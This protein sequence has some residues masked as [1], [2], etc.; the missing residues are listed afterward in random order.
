[1]NIVPQTPQKRC[2]RGDNCVHPMG[3]IQPATAEHFHRSKKCKDGLFTQCKACVLAHK[4]E[5]YLEH[6]AEKLAYNHRYYQLNRESLL[7]DSNDYYAQN[8]DKVKRRIQSY[9]DANRELVRGQWRGFYQRNR[10]RRLEQAKVWNASNPARL[11]ANRHR[12]RARV[13]SVGGTFTKQDVLLAL[14]SQKGR[15]WHC[16]EAVGDKYEV[17]HLIPIARGGS[18]DARNIV[19]SSKGSKLPQ[20]WNG[21]LF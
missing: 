2:T 8:A 13:L 7:Q 17:D 12:R 11:A 16:G 4:R 10:S 14:R 19:I 18:N 6:K 9:R 15:C 5:F 3:C 20:E 1:M 21:K